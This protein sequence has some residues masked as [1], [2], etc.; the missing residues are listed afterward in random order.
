MN[1]ELEK[2]GLFEDEIPQE[3]EFPDDRTES[4]KANDEQ[5]EKL[6]SF[7]AQLQPGA[8]LLIERHQPSWCSGIL[9]EIT[10]SNEALTL[11][12][13]ID[14]WG[15][16]VLGV[17][18]RNARGRFSGGSYKIPL[19]SYPPR[20]YGELITKSQVMDRMRGTEKEPRESAIVVNQAPPKLES[21]AIEKLVAVLPAMVPIILKYIE[22]SAER[23]NREMMMM[24]KM[25]GGGPSSSN[26]IADITKIGLAMSELQKTFGGAGA[27]ASGGGDI[28][29]FIPQALGILE[30]ILVKKSD[31]GQPQGP[32]LTSAPPPPQNV[33]NLKAP[34]NVAQS[35][36]DMAPKNAA[37]TILDAL[38]SMPADKR[39][40]AITEFMS[41][42]QDTMSGDDFEGTND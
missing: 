6:D 1:G 34:S 27:G 41:A 38:G 37:H 24:M 13:F 25:M 15:G 40:Q 14:T 18:L 2:E 21:S 4:E 39:S 35:I 26:N 11:D 5:F 12:Y 32:R 28:V 42:Y 7:F 30:S 16:S 9:E 33:R 36:A 8:T 31:G 3:V 17:K 23:R 19:H 20:V 10:V 29:E 22:N